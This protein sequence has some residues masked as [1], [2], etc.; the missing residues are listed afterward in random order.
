MSYELDRHPLTQSFPAASSIKPRQ[1]VRQ[2]GTSSLFVVPCA[3]ATDRPFGLN[4]LASGGAS[5]LAAGDNVTVYEEL[6]VRKAVAGASFGVGAELIINASGLF[7]PDG[8]AASGH[9]AVGI[10]QTPAAAA[11]EV[12]SLYIKPRKIA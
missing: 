9:W 12:F 11:L 8:I 10:S 2:A 5:G 1:A 7:V 3:T 4:G 6:N